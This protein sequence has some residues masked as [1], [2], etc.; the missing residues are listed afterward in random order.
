VA[1]VLVLLA[2]ARPFQRAGDSAPPIEEKQLSIY[3][4]RVSYSLPVSE[5]NGQDYIALL[6]AL[7]PFGSVSAS[8]DRGKWKL[9]FDN[10]GAEFQR[11]ARLGKVAGKKFGLPS[12]F[13]LE[14]NRGLVPLRAL[15]EILA[16]MLGTKTDYHEASR[17]LFL[18]GAA[19]RFTTDLR[20]DGLSVKFSSPVN[21]LISTEPGKLKMTFTRDPVVSSPSTL[22]PENPLVSSITFSEDNGRAELLVQ[23]KVPLL[24]QFA[25]GGKTIDIV[26]AP[27]QA[28]NAPPAAPQETAT[29]TTAATPATAPITVPPPPTLQS[30]TAKPQFVVMLDAGHGGDDRGALLSETL[31]EKGVTLAFARRLR[32]ELQNHGISAVMS[33]D[34]DVSV[35]VEQRAAM[36]DAAR[37]AVFI[38]LHA[39]SQGRGVRVYTAMLNSAT[40]K[41]GAFVPWDTAQTGHV[42]TSRALASIVKAELSQRE[43]PSTE[44]SAP[45]KP[46]NNIAA[47][48]IAIEIAPS[49]ADVGS[50]NATVYQQRI[51]AAIAEAMVVGRTRVEAER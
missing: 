5:R 29:A 43:I 13:V 34:A 9:R 7:E 31:E 23:G 11:N 18:G 20:E 33:R 4:P 35:P 1:L 48:A 40:S 8:V 24:A 19:T 28:R 51:A 21:P 16:L 26:P 39:T 30:L 27:S 22:R 15:P 38:S 36:A 45:L 2:S 41:P 10:L 37:I 17:R 49:G 12:P 47:T 50:V 32:S 14:N 25:A 46:L 6:E 44:L 3:G 42:L